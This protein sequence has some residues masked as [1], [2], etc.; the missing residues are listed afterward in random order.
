ML[1]SECL[2]KNAFLV[3]ILNAKQEDEAKSLLLPFPARQK[4]R[5]G[6]EKTKEVRPVGERNRFERLREKISLQNPIGLPFCLGKRLTGRERPA[7]K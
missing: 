6:R 5:L 7:L 3:F 1:L 2:L 4:E